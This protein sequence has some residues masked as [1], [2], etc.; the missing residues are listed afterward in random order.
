MFR[1]AT[2][3]MMLLSL[4]SISAILYYVSHGINDPLSMICAILIIIVTW[5]MICSDQMY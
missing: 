4:S 5:K 2:Y 1:I 3:I